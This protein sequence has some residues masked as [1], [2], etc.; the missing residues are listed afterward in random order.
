ML[1]SEMGMI[2]RLF[3]ELFNSVLYGQLGVQWDLSR[4][5][6]TVYLTFPPC[7][8]RY[9]N[10]LQNQTTPEKQQALLTVLKEIESI[11]D[12]ALTKSSRD[13]F[14]MELSK[15]KREISEATSSM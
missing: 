13:S 5:L 4:P 7:L 11:A 3:R 2:S 10:E 1:Y 6:L 9:F 12:H 14:S 15:W 8:E